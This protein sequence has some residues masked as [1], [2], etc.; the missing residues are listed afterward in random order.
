MEGEPNLA[1]GLAPLPDSQRT[2]AKIALDRA[3]D[4]DSACLSQDRNIVARRGPAADA[5][6]A[7]V[8]DQKLIH[9]GHQVLTWNVADAV[10]MIDPAH[11]RKIAKDKSVDRVDGLVALAMAIGL[12]NRELAPIEYDFDR[13]LILKKELLGAMAMDQKK[14]TEQFKAELQKDIEVFRATLQTEVDRAKAQLDAHYDHWRM[15]AQSEREIDQAMLRGI[16]EFALAAL[17][18]ITLINGAA[19][20][21][22]LAFLGNIWDPDQAGAKMAAALIKLCPVFGGRTRATRFRMERSMGC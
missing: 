17:K 22:I 2:H 18:G 1:P 11:G 9:G 15:T 5:L 8:L 6:E 14:E 3:I 21:A 12:Y 10:V 16:I 20:I 19:A 7:A 13:A 4:L